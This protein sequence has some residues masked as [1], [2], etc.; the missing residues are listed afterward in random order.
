MDWIY[1]F[2][3]IGTFVY[4]QLKRNRKAFYLCRTAFRLTNGTVNRL[5][6]IHKELYSIDKLIIVIKRYFSLQSLMKVFTSLSIR[7][8]Y[9][10][11]FGNMNYHS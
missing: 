3:C 4:V 1:D 8:C 5:T 2:F 9:M 11:R 6:Q 10:I 7:K